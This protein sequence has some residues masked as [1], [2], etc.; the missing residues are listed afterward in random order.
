MDEPMK[1][2]P[3]IRRLP[4]RTRQ[5]YPDVDKLL[6]KVDELESRLSVVEGRSQV[7]A[8]RVVRTHA[9]VQ[10]VAEDMALHHPSE[11]EEEE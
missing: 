6:A 5:L 8:A 3:R 7:N 11:H 2:W 4:K 1:L 10:N 9:S